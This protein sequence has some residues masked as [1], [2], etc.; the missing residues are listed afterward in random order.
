MFFSYLGIPL[1]DFAPFSICFVF[2]W[3]LC[4][5]INSVVVW[6]YFWEGNPFSHSDSKAKTYFPNK[7]LLMLLF[8]YNNEINYSVT[9]ALATVYYLL[10][11]R[12]IVQTLDDHVLKP[13]ARFQR[14]NTKRRTIIFVICISITILTT[15]FLVTYSE[16]LSLLV[17]KFGHL[18]PYTMLSF[19]ALYINNMVIILPLA[20][21]HYIQWTTYQH[22]SSLFH[23]LYFGDLANTRMICKQVKRIATGNAKLHRLNSFPLLLF[24]LSN[25][26][27]T[28][29]SV[30]LISIGYEFPLVYVLGTTVYPLYSACL[31]MKTQQVLKAIAKQ[32]NFQIKLNHVKSIRVSRENNNFER[33]YNSN[34]TAPVL[35]LF[36]IYKS[37]FE[38]TIFNLF[39]LNYSFLLSLSFFVMSYTVFILQT[40]NQ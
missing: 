27:D 26:V 33:F 6:K 10:F 5:M 32:T 11:G 30:C 29:L 23:A 2:Q 37:S 3:L 9:Y 38:I 20:I 34:F 31:A 15:F 21:T 8:H 25:T 13:T 22:V 14:E 18:T 17:A 16:I 28:V 1:A 35:Y 12:K 19:V 39:S 4:L 40:K 7:P 36:K 24:F